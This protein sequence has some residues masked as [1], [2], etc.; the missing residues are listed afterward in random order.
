MD[1]IFVW[2]EQLQNIY[3]KHSRIVDKAIQFV[4]ALTTFLIIN[5]NIGYM[6]VLAK[7]IVVLALT[8]ICTFLP[9]IFTALAA[10]VLVLLHLYKLS[11]GVALVVAGVIFIMFAFY[12]RFTPKKTL[13]LLLTPIAFAF[14]MPVVIPIAF[15]LVGGPINVVPITFGV[16]TF[17][18]LDYIKVAAKTVVGADA[19]GMMGV[20]VVMLQSILQNKQMWVTVI[21]FT[22]CLL[23]VYAIRRQAIAHAWEIAII[24]GAVIYIIA[25][26]TGSIALNV[27]VAYGVVL[28]GTVASAVISCVLEL[29]VFTVDYS[30][31]ERLQYEDDEYY[32]Y[33]KAVPKITITAPE[34]TVKHINERRDP[35][36]QKEDRPVKRAR[37]PRPKKAQKRTEKHIKETEEMMLAKTIQDE[38][39]I[40]KIVEEELKN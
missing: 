2:K 13:I 38:L 28:L 3:A 40:Q 33:V 25:M 20:V 27:T 8:V 23:T 16:I 29:F 35:E 12:F 6:S 11:I 39:D 34:K 9:M 7:P 37:K 24:S 10:A 1:N 22:I 26:V 32:Y 30:R 17:F 19:S 31:T 18:M 15:A 5:K 36:E 21:A 14:K 4:L